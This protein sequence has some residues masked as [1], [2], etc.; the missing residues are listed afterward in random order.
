[1]NAVVESKPTKRT[2]YMYFEGW[3]GAHL[4]S[5]VRRAQVFLRKELCLTDADTLANMS[6]LGMSALLAFAEGQAS[7]DAERQYSVAFFPKEEMFF[8]PT[9]RDALRRA[10]FRWDIFRYTPSFGAFVRC[11]SSAGLVAESDTK[12]TPLPSH[13]VAADEPPPLVDWESPPRPSGWSAA[14]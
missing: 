13:G 4:D 9:E 3:R 2:V 5:V 11:E 1:M 14:V 8:L 6:Y 12:P 10:S 7:Q